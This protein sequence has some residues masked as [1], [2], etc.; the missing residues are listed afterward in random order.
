M[1]AAEGPDR[2]RPEGSGAVSAPPSAARAPMRL[3][4]PY[5]DQLDT[6]KRLDGRLILIAAHELMFAPLPFTA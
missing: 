1:H 2:R 3:D 5:L 4:C 6:L